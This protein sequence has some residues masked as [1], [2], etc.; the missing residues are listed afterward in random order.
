[1]LMEKIRKL[2]IFDSGLGGFS[3]FKDL[4]QAYP[5]LEMILYADQ[6]NAPYGNYSK[7]KIIELAIESMQWFKNQGI[8]DVLL[9][10]NT[11]SSTALDVLQSSFSDMRIYGIIDLTLSQLDEDVDCV[12]VVATSATI[13]SNAYQNLYKGTMIQRALPD[14]AKSIENLSS[15]EVIEAQ[16][17]QGLKGLEGCEYIILGCTHYPL[18][19]D[20]FE[21]VSK[22]KFL[23]SRRPI[24]EFIC[25]N[26]WPSKHKSR[27]VT[28][29]DSVYFRHQIEALDKD[30]LEDV[31]WK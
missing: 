20:S 3:V 28:T 7:D 15:P 14:L 26:Y 6:K 22:A 19:L 5:D 2:G 25:G 16:L 17:T 13:A 8:S 21:R 10:C 11:V 18:V 23:D 30:K 27:V 9:A 29:G 4:K 1:M 24:R 31:V 12:G